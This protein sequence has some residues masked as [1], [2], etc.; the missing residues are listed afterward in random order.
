MRVPIESEPGRQAGED[1]DERGAVRLAR[2][3]QTECHDAKPRASLMTSTGASTPVHSSNAATPCA[4]EDLEAGD[5]ACTRRPRGHGR[6]RLRVR[7]VDERLAGGD[8][9]DDR[10]ALR[11]RVHHEI[12]PRRPRAARLPDARTAARPAAPARSGRGPAVADDHRSLRR[13]PARA[14]PHPSSS[15]RRVRHG[16][17]SVLTDG[18]S[19]SQKAGRRACAAS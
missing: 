10:I 8:L 17:T 3:C 13:E 19:V 15:P 4:S 2:R 1:R 14:R 5:D 9:D 6:R 11:G 18:A 7:E 12:A 16:S